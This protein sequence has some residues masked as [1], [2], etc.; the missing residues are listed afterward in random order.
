MDTPVT[1]NVLRNLGAPV[2]VWKLDG[3]RQRIIG[4]TGEPETELRYLR[5]T[6]NLLADVEEQWD[7]QSGLEK[8]IRSKSFTTMR[9]L[10]AFAW[11]MST[12]FAVAAGDDSGERTVGE[13]LIETETANYIAAFACAL[14][15]ANGVDPTTAAELLR[16]GGDAAKARGEWVTQQFAELATIPPETVVELVTAAM[17]ESTGDSG[18]SDG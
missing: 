14:A 9:R 8:A 16:V 4:P 7:S 13:L 1:A 2:R 6:H 10:F 5:F 17:D 11:G 3:N 18:S 12:P 15:L